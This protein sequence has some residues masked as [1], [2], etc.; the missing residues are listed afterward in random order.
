MSSQNENSHSKEIRENTQHSLPLGGDSLGQP[1]DYEPRIL[2]ETPGEKQSH[3]DFIDQDKAHHRLPVKKREAPDMP[4]PAPSRPSVTPCTIL[5]FNCSTYK[6]GS[7]HFQVGSTQ[8]PTFIRTGLEI[9]GDPESRVET[10]HSPTP[11]G[12]VLRSD[13]DLSTVFTRVNC[14]TYEAGSIHFE[15]GSTR[16]TTSLSTVV[17]YGLDV[18]GDDEIRVQTQQPPTPNGEVV[19]SG[20]D[21]S[22][23]E[24]TLDP[25]LAAAE[26]GPGNP[27]ATSH[28]FSANLG[29][30]DES[31]LDEETLSDDNE[32]TQDASPGAA[33]EGDA[34]RILFAEFI[35]RVRLRHRTNSPE[36]NSAP[37]ADPRPPTAPEAGAPPQRYSP[38][39]STL[40]GPSPDAE[41]NTPR[42]WGTPCDLP[43]VIKWPQAFVTD[44][45]TGLSYPAPPPT[46]WSIGHDGVWK[47]VTPSEAP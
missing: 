23:S 47:I 16:A 40:P 28:I 44:R 43:R 33:G 36:L 38:R 20:P 26:D 46:V 31:T 29:E 7:V 3:H 2:P 6:A 10:Q 21:L 22:K 9:A 8:A 37:P 34:M 17:L 27:P 12:D 42:D 13:Y 14:S 30:Q 24:D 32:E 35:Q 11:N 41:Y 18:A 15:V 39:L 25:A 5:D 45:S 1:Q 4:T 19:D